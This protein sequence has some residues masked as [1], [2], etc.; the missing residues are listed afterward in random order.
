MTFEEAIK[1]YEKVKK[2]HW[3][4]KGFYITADIAGDIVDAS[5]IPVVLN[6]LDLEDDW[7]EYTEPQEILDKEEKE[8]LRAV[9]KPFR[10]RI[11][12]ITRFDSDDGI[13]I[14]LKCSEVPPY[15]V[16]VITLPWFIKKE[17][18]RGMIIRKRYTLEELGL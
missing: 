16:G 12:Y 1:K 10:N 8:Y 15:N 11:D 9:I 2:S 14:S 18:Y 3:Q 6:I 7:E 13:V 5:G 4:K 17:A